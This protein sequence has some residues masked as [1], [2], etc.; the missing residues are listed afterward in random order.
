MF[1]VSN[2]EFLIYFYVLASAYKYDKIFP[3]K[4]S[5]IK[6]SLVSLVKGARE[7]DPETEQL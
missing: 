1:P 3:K 4:Q 7:S 6:F 5:L 2:N